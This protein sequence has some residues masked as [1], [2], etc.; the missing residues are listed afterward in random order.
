MVTVRRTLKLALALVALLAVLY[1]AAS[2]YIARSALDADVKPLG[3]TPAA[4]GLAYEDVEFSPRGW[5]EITLRGWWIP[6][7][8][9]R[10]TVIRVHGVDSNR[11]SLLGLAAPLTD[12]GYSVLVFDL[13]GHG[14]SDAARMGAGLDE[15]DDVLGAIDY[16]I[17]ERGASPGAIF[18]HGNSYGGAI[19]LMTGWREPAVAGVYADSAFASLPDLVAQEVARRTVLPAWAAS[20]LRPG[21][22]L[23]SRWVYGINLNDVQP[24][25]DA[26]EYP[27]PLGLAHCR[28]DERIAIA[29]Y[30]RIRTHLSDTR[31]TTVFENCPHSDAWHIHPAQYAA[32][33]LHYLEARLQ[34]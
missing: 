18:L 24:W 16:I 33:L 17:R 10:A 34:R 27:Y 26:A 28:P 31:F 3:E 11:N 9:P 1:V 5:E 2:V 15:R 32:A 22:G 7:A 4:L 29:H 25:R 20:A 23:I 14:E 21:I 6:A 19:A 13:R 12:A 30:E 8:E